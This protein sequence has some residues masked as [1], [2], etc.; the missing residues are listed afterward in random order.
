VRA[1]DLGGLR[2]GQPGAPGSGDGEHVDGGGAADQRV[3]V[4]G[5]EFPAQI[6]GKLGQAGAGPDHR[7][8]IGGWRARP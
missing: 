6:E 7:A 1:Y 3:H 5:F 2:P 4:E 8:E